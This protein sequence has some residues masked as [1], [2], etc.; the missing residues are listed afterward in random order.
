ML[1]RS[2]KLLVLPS[3]SEAP[4]FQLAARP[5]AIIFATDPDRRPAPPTVI[6]R[7]RYGLTRAEAAFALEILKGDGIQ[8]CADR[9]G[10]TRATAR[11]HLAHIFR[12]TDTRRQAELVRLIMGL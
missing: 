12:K 10:I 11:T 8:A 2:I 9:L 6:I 3:R 4:A 1:F 7:Q 5:V